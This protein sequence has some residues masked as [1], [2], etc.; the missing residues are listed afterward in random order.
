LELDFVLR[1][2]DLTARTDTREDLHWSTTGEFAPLTFW[3]NCSDLF[4]W[5]TADGVPVNPDNVGMLQD[6]LTEVA[7]RTGGDY[8]YGPQLFA[9]RVRQRRPQNASY[10]PDARLHEL[11]DAC[12]AAREIGFDNP[13]SEQERP[14]DPALSTEEPM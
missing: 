10:P 5:G 1:V 8:A 14:H 4:D 6:A 13:K 7:A 2:L 3:I 12:G 11:F 9:C